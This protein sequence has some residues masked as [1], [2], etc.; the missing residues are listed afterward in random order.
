MNTKTRFI[1]YS[2]LTARKTGHEDECAML[3]PLSKALLITVMLHFGLL[4]RS[5]FTEPEDGNQSEK[6]AFQDKS[7]ERPCL[8]NVVK[9]D[10]LTYVLPEQAK[11]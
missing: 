7:N 9:Q 6:T 5:A 4:H 1:V 10:R 3:W 2:L 8:D 11:R